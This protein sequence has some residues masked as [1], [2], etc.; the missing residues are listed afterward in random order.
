M[1]PQNVGS[2]QAVDR[3]ATLP[4]RLTFTAEYIRTA[5]TFTA[6]YIRAFDEETA[7]STNADTLVAAMK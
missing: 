4:S 7:R 6:E 2:A 3:D 5:L 1:P